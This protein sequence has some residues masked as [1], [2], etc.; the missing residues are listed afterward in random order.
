MKQK[1]LL[2]VAAV[3]LSSANVFAGSDRFTWGYWALERGDFPSAVQHFKIGADA[4][5]TDCREALAHMYMVGLGTSKNPSKAL[6]LL[7]VVYKEDPVFWYFFYSGVNLCGYVKES[8]DILRSYTV[9]IPSGF[10]SIPKLRDFYDNGNFT[11]KTLGVSP[12]VKQAIK[13]LKSIEYSPSQWLDG[14]CESFFSGVA[15][16]S[17]REAREFVL[18]YAEKVNDEELLDFLSSNNKEISVYRDSV[19]Y[20]KTKK[21]VESLKVYIGK[22]KTRTWIEKA[23]EAY[24]KAGYVSFFSHVQNNE[25]AQAEAVI[26]DNSIVNFQLAKRV[27]EFKNKYDAI[28]KKIEAGTAT[29]DELDHFIKVEIENRKSTY[30]ADQKQMADYGFVRSTSLLDEIKSEFVAVFDS[31]QLEASKTWD[32]TTEFSAMND[33]ITSVTDEKC[34]MQMIETYQGVLLDKAAAWNNTTKSAEMDAMIDEKYVNEDTKAKLVAT[35]QKVALDKEATWDI[36]TESTEMDDMIDAKYINDETKGKLLATYQKIALERMGTTKKAK[37]IS[38]IDAVTGT[39]YSMKHLDALT[40]QKVEKMEEKALNKTVPI[41]HFG[42]AGIGGITGEKKASDLG[43]G[44]NI[45]LGRPSHWFNIYAGGFYTWH[46]GTWAEPSLELYDEYGWVVSNIDYG[47]KYK[48]VEIPVEL[49]FNYARSSF[50]SMYLGMGAS[51]NLMME[52][53]MYIFEEPLQNEEYAKL[54][55]GLNEN[56]LAGRVSLGFYAVGIDMSIY[57]N[58]NLSSP[59]NLDGQTDKLGEYPGY[60][61]K[62]IAS[63]ITTGLKVGIF[64]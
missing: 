5:Y 19:D 49:R 13:Y 7:K 26:A 45:L 51:Y 35:C 40:R 38:D 10:S 37:N 56:Y 43:L 11:C 48:K 55:D 46:N 20:A 8:S 21:D 34:K 42:V 62:Q 59:Y 57:V 54:T 64:F 31:M 52:G 4:G 22:A 15:E 24:E 39:V 50:G 28:K 41:I 58:Y 9:T 16:K 12:D 36:A 3:L 30:P 60:V 32:A 14:E 23:T 18:A 6:S 53:S 63:K 61:Q 47:I 25:W 27:I 33:L 2:L 17:E 29:A 44:A 1:L